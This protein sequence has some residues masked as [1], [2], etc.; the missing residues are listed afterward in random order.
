LLSCAAEAVHRQREGD[1][2]ADHQQQRRNPAGRKGEG[3]RIEL[4]E[5]ALFALVI[6]HVQSIDHRL[7][8]G[9]GAPERQHNAE[10]EGE[11]EAG[12][13]LG[14]HAGDLVLHDLE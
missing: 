3:E 14:Q 1:H 6:D 7:D 5:T 13:P 10:Q 8:A 4:D 11:A 12:R 2:G 9:I